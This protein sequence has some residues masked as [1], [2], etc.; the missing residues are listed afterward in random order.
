MIDFEEKRALPNGW[1]IGEPYP[2][3]RQEDYVKQMTKELLERPRPKVIPSTIQ[4]AST[5]AT[6]D[7]DPKDDEKHWNRHLPTG[8][9][10]E[11]KERPLSP[12]EILPFES[13]RRSAKNTLGGSD[14]SSVDQQK[15][16][17]GMEAFTYSKPAD[18]TKEQRRKVTRLQEI[19]NTPLEPPKPKRRF[20][21]LLPDKEPMSDDDFEAY[22]HPKWWEIWR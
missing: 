21:G 4:C 18:L 19:V 11:Q 8:V 2:I 12:A 15:R 6:L 16:Q 14:I 13:A 20:F 9:Q 22:L 17:K 7:R 1:R 3:S 10:V 5:Q